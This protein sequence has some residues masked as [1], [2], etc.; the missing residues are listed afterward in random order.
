MILINLLSI[1]LVVPE[2]LGRGVVDESIQHETIRTVLKTCI[3]T[4]IFSAMIYSHII[5]IET[6]MMIK[7]TTARK[8]IISNNFLPRILIAAC[9]EER[10]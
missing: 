8:A 10:Y 4:P 7:A 2:L 3:V 1:I 9:Q 5:I 6:N